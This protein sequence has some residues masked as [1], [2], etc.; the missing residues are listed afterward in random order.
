MQS[1]AGFH[2]DVC[3]LHFKF[4]RSSQL[5]FVA[6]SLLCW[7][8]C[9]EALAGPSGPLP[10]WPVGQE[11]GLAR[12]GLGVAGRREATL[13]RGGCGMCGSPAIVM[14]PRQQKT[15]LAA[16]SSGMEDATMN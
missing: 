4:L 12:L 15:A 8:S 16:F 10:A 5:R 11:G 3:F 14:A 9:P 1:L 7:Q 13:P 6:R 2:S